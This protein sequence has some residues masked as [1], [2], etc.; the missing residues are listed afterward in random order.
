MKFTTTTIILLHC[1]SSVQGNACIADGETFSLDGGCDQAAFEVGLQAHLTSIGC[2][3]DAK[4]ELSHIYGSEAD[5][6]ISVSN[7]CSTAWAQ[8]SSSSFDDIDDRFTNS[9]MNQYV[10]GD[11][12]LNSKYKVHHI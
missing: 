6:V 9:F 4:T 10:N 8:V 5:A 7:V 11:T 12:F 2:N 1:I 3:H